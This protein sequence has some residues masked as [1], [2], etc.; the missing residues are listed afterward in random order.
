M[1]NFVLISVLMLCAMV[2][3][4]I[5]CDYLMHAQTDSLTRYRVQLQARNATLDGVLAVKIID[6]NINGVVVNDFGIK[7]FAFSIS[8]DRKKVKLQ[9]VMPMLNHWYIK[10]VLK[11]DLKL[12]FNATS[13]DKQSTNNKTQ[14]AVL[15]DG[16][17]KMTNT[18]YKIEYLFTEAQVVET[19]ELESEDDEIEAEYEITE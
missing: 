10:R 1:R 11:N 19:Q 14:I 5:D 6:G 7:A 17:I 16:S 12:L 15:N 13:C 18:K 8:N 9:D 3:N 4:A 2:A